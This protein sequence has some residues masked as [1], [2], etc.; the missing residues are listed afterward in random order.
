MEFAGLWFALT[1][2]NSLQL[3]PT[4]QLSPIGNPR[5]L[6]SQSLPEAPRASQTRP[7]H[8]PYR[9]PYRTGPHHKPENL[10]AY[11][12]L[13]LSD[14]LAYGLLPLSDRVYGLGFRV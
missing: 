5:V 10:L 13:P 9:P 7:H 14:L 8:R 1:L 2:S 12:L 4:L 11:G 6:H 3:S